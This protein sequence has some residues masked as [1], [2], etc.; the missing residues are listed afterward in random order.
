ME[1]RG[2]PEGDGILNRSRRH[3]LIMTCLAGVAAR[4]LHRPVA[5][6]AGDNSTFVDLALVLAAD[7]SYSVTAEGYRLQQ[8][9]Y[10]D[11]FRDPR[12]AAALGSGPAGAVAVTYF[13]WSGASIRNQ[14][15]GWTILR[16]RADT[17][18]LADALETAPRTVFR[19]G[20]SIS[21]AID[22]G[23]HL[24]ADAGITAGRRI[25]DISGDGRNNN[26]R[27]APQARDE[28]VADGITIN[29][30]PIL[31]EEPD[32]DQFYAANVIGGPGAFLI[33][34]QDFSAFADAIRQKLILEIAASD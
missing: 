34:A 20:T 15:T 16:S 26:G 22:F 11:A 1:G 33:P 6:G 17:E 28:A 14:V 31:H 21:G 24:L 7:C 25:I 3:I 9:G 19:G 13:Q 30:L 4:F 32:I 29:G 27:P 18:R 23:R 2:V 10:A 12:I 5:A 8:K